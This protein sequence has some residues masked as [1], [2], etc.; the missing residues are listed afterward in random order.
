[1]DAR[2]DAGAGPDRDPARFVDAGAAPNLAFDGG[3]GEG[4]LTVERATTRSIEPSWI[5]IA[6]P[7]TAWLRTST[8]LTSA[9]VV[10][11]KAPQKPPL[12]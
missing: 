2:G 8:P 4:G 6:D 11:K 3:A 12:A 1:M 10:M 9:A 5:V 7:L